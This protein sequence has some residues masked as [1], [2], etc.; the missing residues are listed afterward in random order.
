MGTARLVSLMVEVFVSSR[1][2]GNT[3]SSARF[4]MTQSF[5]AHP[6]T[7]FLAENLP[8]VVLLL[9]GIIDVR[10]DPERSVIA[11]IYTSFSL[12]FTVVKA[13]NVVI[14]IY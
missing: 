13:T 2:K 7:S 4:K 5:P 12:V 6:K 10:R 9:S 14:C 3:P 1:L 11:S 8:P